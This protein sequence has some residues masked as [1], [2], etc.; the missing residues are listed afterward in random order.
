MTY[1]CCDCPLKSKCLGERNKTNLRTIRQDDR[2]VYYEMMN[3]KIK[4]D[5]DKEMMKKGRTT[6]EPVIGNLKSNVGYRR[7]RL[8]GLENVKGE[9]ILV[10]IGHNVN[11]M[12]GL[13]FFIF[14]AL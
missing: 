8:R 4:N 12:F 6:V 10:C 7:F 2:Q 1:E 13:L 5:Q 9:F 11:K 3:K 14:I